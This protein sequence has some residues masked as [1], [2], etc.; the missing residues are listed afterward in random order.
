MRVKSSARDNDDI[1]QSVRV[2]KSKR[3]RRVSLRAD[4]AAGCVW[5]V[6]PNRTSLK[7]AYK[8]ANTRRHWIREQLDA[9]P[10]PVAFEHGARLPLLGT[11]KQIVICLDTTSRKT[12]ISLTEKE[13]RISSN[14][15]DIH[16]NLMRY[17]K[18][19]A[20]EAI[21]RHA[22]AKATDINHTIHKITLRDP[23]SRWGSCS[24]DGNLSFSWRLIFA[25][26]EAF[27]YVI[28]HEVAHLK[29]LDHSKA[30]WA[31]C[32]QLSHDFE[33]GHYWMRDHGTELQAY[34][35]SSDTI[36]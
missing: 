13:I 24:S 18:R 6:V 4:A 35:K 22:N 31:T 19:Y 26:F 8:F 20:R 17:L 34:G 32:R 36:I 10:R 5:L 1:V 7:K 28:A 23:K 9:M 14:R 30:F 11:E 29:H 33:T 15:L 3:A 2:R 25:P 21:T 12:D 27:D 16:N